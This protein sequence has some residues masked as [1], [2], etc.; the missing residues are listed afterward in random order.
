MMVL[1]RPGRRG[2]AV[3]FSGIGKKLQ[4]M[5]Q[6]QL[7]GKVTACLEMSE[8]LENGLSAGTR[9]LEEMSLLIKKLSDHKTAG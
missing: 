2:Q 3:S 5:T 8:Q 7:I 6:A 9:K 1:R 4:T